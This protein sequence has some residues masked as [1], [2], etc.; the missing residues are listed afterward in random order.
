MQIRSKIKLKA[1]SLRF[2]TVLLALLFLLLSACSNYYK[3]DYRDTTPTS[4]KLNVYYDEGLSLQVENQAYTFE[5]LYAD[6][7]LTLFSSTENKA[8]E[9]LY[10]D[11][12]EAIVI[13]RQLTDREKKVFANRNFEPKFSAVAKSGMAL[14]AN[15]ATPIRSI[16]MDELKQLLTGNAALRDTSGQP[17]ELKI[18]LDK[19][20][21]SIVHY[22]TDSLIGGLKLSPNCSVLASSLDAINYVA[23]N[24]NT[25]ALL[26]F[27]WLSD[28]D[29]SISKANRDKIKFIGVRRPGSLEVHYP[30]Q[31]SFKLGTYPYTRT[32]YVYRK[33]GDFTIAKGFESFVAGPKGQVTFLKQGLL[34]TKQQERS[35]HINMEPIKIQ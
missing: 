13:S 21:S 19:N 3:N 14:I 35:I 30:S 11:S 29:D 4:G 34:P 10:Q 1:H 23:A 17:I 32:I 15:V 27:A 18:L 28:V 12:C 26:D 9:A 16:D 24:K 20:H 22:V 7:D 31:S 25:L 33:T 8:I 6:V 2:L 5:A